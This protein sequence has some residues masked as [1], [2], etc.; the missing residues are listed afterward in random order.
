M[1]NGELV[2][3]CCDASIAYMDAAVRRLRGLFDDDPLAQSIDA[4]REYLFCT[5]YNVESQYAPFLEIAE[6]L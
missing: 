5:H 2:F 3:V 1:Q 6:G 4:G